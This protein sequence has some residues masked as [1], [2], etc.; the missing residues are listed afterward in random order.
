MVRRYALCCFIVIV[1]VA[2]FSWANERILT[3]SE[4]PTNYQEKGKITGTT[5]EIVQEILRLL[6][7]DTKIEMLPWA[8]VMNLMARSEN[9]I[10]F[11]AGKSPERVKHGYHF[12]GPVSTRKHILWKRKNSDITINSLDQVVSQGLSIGIMK[13][14][15]RA[16]YFQEKGANVHETT[17]HAQS[18][19]KLVRN[20]IDLW[21]SSDLAVRSLSRQANVDF[22]T[23][24]VA[25]VFQ[26]A[27]SYIM[28]SK[29]SSPKLQKRWQEAFKQIQESGFMQKLADDW[30]RKLNIPFAYSNKDGLYVLS[31]TNN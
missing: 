19:R 8:R 1:L 30:S 15:W 17:S 14:D 16:R 2:N 18:L 22:D 26:Q 23:L 11:T 20:R 9:I 13:A 12:L 31:G 6:E 24:E 27:P 21:V 5:T 29:N 25:F 10:A 3:T 28:F 4:A 7:S